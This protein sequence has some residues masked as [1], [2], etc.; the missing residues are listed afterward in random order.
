MIIKLTLSIFFDTSIPFEEQT[1][2]CQLLINDIITDHPVSHYN[3]DKTNRPFECVRVF[4]DSE[5]VI[6]S[7]WNTPSPS[8]GVEKEIKSAR[9]LEKWY[10]L[11]KKMQIILTDEINYELLKEYP[12]MAFLVK[13]SEITSFRVNGKI[14]LYMDMIEDQFGRLLEKHE[15]EIT[16]K[17]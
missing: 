11:S 6:T 5:I 12:E 2:D 3:F 13:S 14:F 9:V 8:C 17:N 15:A 10:D 16:I 1:E 7:I 4:G